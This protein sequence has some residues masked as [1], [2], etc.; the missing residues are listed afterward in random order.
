MVFCL[1]CECAFSMPPK[2]HLAK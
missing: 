2:C 1:K